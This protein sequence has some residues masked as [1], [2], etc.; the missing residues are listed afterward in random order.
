MK[1]SKF[2]YKDKVELLSALENGKDTRDTS[3]KEEQDSIEA[4]FEESKEM[5][6]NTFL[7]QYNEKYGNIIKQYRETQKMKTMKVLYS[8]LN[9]Y[10]DDWE[11][12]MK[13]IK[14]LYGVAILYIITVVIGVIAGIVY[15]VG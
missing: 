2:Y 14:V 12:I 1:A 7:T 5:D 8:A 3:T 13:T 6:Y 9:P 11:M 4:F 10:G 15:F